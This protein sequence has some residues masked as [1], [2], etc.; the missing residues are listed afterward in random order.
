MHV[1]EL[2]ANM[3]YVKPAPEMFERIA[4]RIREYTIESIEAGASLW[5]GDDADTWGA[6][7]DRRLNAF[8]LD[9]TLPLA[10]A[11]IPWIERNGRER[12]NLRID[13][14]SV[15]G[16]FELLREPL[17]RLYIQLHAPYGADVEV[18][19]LGPSCSLKVSTL[20]SHDDRL[21]PLLDDLEA[22]ARDFIEVP[23][24]QLDSE[25]FRVFIGHGGDDQWRVLRDE[26]RDYHGFEV[27]AFERKPRAGF[28]I[29]EVLA[30][31][32]SESS[33]AVLVFTGADEMA[34]GAFHARQNVVHEL[35][36]FQG[37]FGWP[38]AIALVEDGV[39]LFSN[40]DGTQQIRFPK[41]MIRAAIGELVSTLADRRDTRG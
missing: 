33:V 35:G 32:A 20:V 25:P 38:N 3:Y 16:A 22:I 10:Y 28:T 34:D 40:L 6:D 30:R 4:A 26:L 9:G 29:S 21:D 15:D 41:G 7:Y 31:M 2:T 11:T 24:I 23:T 8:E 37:K 17:D 1:A 27:V 12:A 36:Y 18:N 13:D 19:I 39:E 5:G 14:V